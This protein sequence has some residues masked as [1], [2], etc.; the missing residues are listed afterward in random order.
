MR[1]IIITL[2]TL[3]LI[4]CNEKTKVKDD[5]VDKIINITIETSTDKYVEFPDLYDKLSQEILDDKDEKLIIVEKLKAKGFKITNYGKG[6]YAPF[7]PR[8][9]NV[10][11]QKYGCECEVDKIYYVTISDSN[12]ITTERI[13]CRFN[14]LPICEGGDF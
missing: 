9:I 8:I 6:N 5:F 11:L 3:S 1:K 14:V 12:F 2:V 10:T 7:G 4:S 13:R